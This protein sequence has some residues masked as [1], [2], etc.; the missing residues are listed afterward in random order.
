VAEYVHG[1]A[2]PEQERL[3]AQAEH[4]RHDLIADGTTLPPG[5]HAD[6]STTTSKPFSRP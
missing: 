4:W 6:P 3:V 1:Y 2:T 5:C